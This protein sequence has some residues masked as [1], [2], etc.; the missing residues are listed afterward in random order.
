[1]ANNPFEWL[2]LGSMV[3]TACIGVGFAAAETVRER[4]ERRRRCASPRGHPVGCADM[5]WD[6]WGEWR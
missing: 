6:R 4:R 3:L 2:F 1:M 5:H